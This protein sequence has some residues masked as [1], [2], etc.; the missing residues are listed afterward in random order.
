MRP[1]GLAVV[2]SPS[3]ACAGRGV[4]HAALADKREWDRIGANAVA[5]DAA[6]GVGGAKAGGWLSRTRNL[7]VSLL[8]PEDEAILVRMNALEQR[9]GA[10]DTG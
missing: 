1:I 4:L 3:H 7:R 2:R 8:L 5:C 6:G 9:H 10:A